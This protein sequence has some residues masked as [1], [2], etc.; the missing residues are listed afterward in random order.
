MK[1]IRERAQELVS[2]VVEA[3][4]VSKKEELDRTGSSRDIES[5]EMTQPACF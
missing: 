4:E 5:T 2:T 3:R 1:R